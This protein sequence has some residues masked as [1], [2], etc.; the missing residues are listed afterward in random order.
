LEDDF[1]YDN[2]DSTF[3]FF[4]FDEMMNKKGLSKKDKLK[5]LAAKKM[6]DKGK[7][8]ETPNKNP[9]LAVKRAVSM[10]PKEKEEGE[11]EDKENQQ[12]GKGDGHDTDDSD[13]AFWAHKEAQKKKYQKKAGPLFVGGTSIESAG[14]SG[15]VRE[16]DAATKLYTILFADG[17]SAQ[18]PE[19]EVREMVCALKGEDDVADMEEEEE[20]EEEEESGDEE[21]R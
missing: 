12:E 18:L 15:S 14:M 8:K 17:S 2:P 20:E 1:D 5:A 4:I 19:E 7:D 11:S 6:K 3:C 9:A 16:F 10:T 21:V 13:D